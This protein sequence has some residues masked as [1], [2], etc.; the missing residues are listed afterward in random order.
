VVAVLALGPEEGIESNVV[1]ATFVGNTRSRATF[2]ASSRLAGDP[3]QT[4]ISG[5]VLD[6]SNN[7]IQGVTLHIEGT[8][9]TTQSDAR[10][11]LSYNPRQSD[12]YS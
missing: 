11:N 10:D 8:R 1:K 9:L 5:V 12:M 2:V 7:P 6:N 3:A 4:R